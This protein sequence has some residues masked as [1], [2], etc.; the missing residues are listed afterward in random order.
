MLLSSPASPN[1]AS[2]LA[3]R[4]KPELRDSS[5]SPAPSSPLA[6]PPTRTSRSP[7]LPTPSTAKVAQTM[8]NSRE[9][10]PE[11]KS[12]DKRIRKPHP[13]S[14]GPSPKPSQSRGSSP[15]P[16]R[17]TGSSASSGSPTPSPPTAYRPIQSPIKLSSSEHS[18]RSYSPV[19]APSHSP[20]PQQA[21][22]VPEQY[23]RDYEHDR[24]V[25]KSRHKHRSEKRERHKIRERSVS[26]EREHRRR[27]R[28]QRRNKERDYYRPHNRDRSRERDR[29]RRVE[30]YRR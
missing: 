1:A 11:M 17:K 30:V 5:R 15:N 3:S 7:L 12:E 27:H 25:R 13:C 10:S 4:L 26:R 28:D 2:P 16:A 18:D 24:R 20:D 22:G 19:L 21:N 29:A 9:S 23:R 14:P 8:E 6:L